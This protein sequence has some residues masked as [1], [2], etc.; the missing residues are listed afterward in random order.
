MTVKLQFLAAE[1]K[2]YLKQLARSFIE[3]PERTVELLTEQEQ[4]GALGCF[5]MRDK[6]TYIEPATE[7][8]REKCFKQIQADVTAL[9]RAKRWPINNIIFNLQF[10]TYNV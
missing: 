4:G 10:K 1:R 5:K 9:C 2:P 3:Q 8:Q 6:F 7:K